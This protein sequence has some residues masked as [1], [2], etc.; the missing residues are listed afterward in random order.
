MKNVRSIRGLALTGVAA[1]GL[2]AMTPALADSDFATN[3][4]TG[5]SADLNFE[6]VIPEFISFQVGS[7]GTTVDLVQFN[8]PAADV[9][10]QNPVSRSN[11]GGAAIPVTLLSNVGNLAINAVGSTGGT[12]DIDWDQITASSSD[13][14]ALPAPQVNGSTGVTA[15]ADGVIDASADWTFVYDN[16]NVVGAGTYTGTVTYT[17]ATP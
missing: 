4:T 2:I 3:S 15:D 6:V 16:T 1:L 11:A 9:G 5:A 13:V 14:A 12:N 10:D 8:V 17:A 7:S